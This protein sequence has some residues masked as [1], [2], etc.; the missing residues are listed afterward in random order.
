MRKLLGPS[1]VSLFF[2][3]T[4]HA[5]VLSYGAPSPAGFAGTLDAGGQVPFSGSPTFSLRVAGTTNP[6][7]G[8]LLVGGA[9]V[10]LPVLG[11]T[12]LVDP[13]TAALI[14]FPA[15]LT[16]LPIPIPPAPSIVGGTAYAQV[17]I[18]NGAFPPLGIALT[19]AVSV[20][21]LP[22]PTPT[23]AYFGLQDFSFGAN[24]P[25]QM[26]I[27]DLTTVPPSFR[28]TGNLGFSG[29]IASNFSPKVAVPEQAGFAYALGSQSVNQ[30]VRVLDVASDPA[31]IVTYASLGDIPV[32]LPI[33][34][35]VGQRECETTPDNSLLFVTSGNSSATVL[36]E[37]FD[38][39]SLPGS[40]PTAP[41][42]TIS[43]ATAGS[44]PV[45]LDVSPDGTMLAVLAGVDGNPPVRIYSINPAAPAP[46]SLA[47]SL[48]L[49][50]FTG[51]ADPHD[52]HFAPDGSLLFVSGGN[53]TFA[54]VDLTGPAPLTLINGGAWPTPATSGDHGSAV[55]V[56]G[57]ALVGVLGDGMTSGGPQYYV[58]DLNTTSASFGTLLASFTTNAVGGNI[59]NH[60][61]HARGSIVV[62]IDG[63]GAT[64]DCEWID[65]VDLNQPDPV[66]GFVSWRVKA[67]TFTNL[68]PTGLSSIPR[69]FDIR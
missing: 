67:P 57:G 62:A 48:T 34:D 27:L 69:D 55:A 6:I 36:L 30:F 15:P 60:R 13:T 44:G 63:G 52:V 43:Y 56:M 31:G 35:W 20:E 28:A 2:A 58:I 5:Q 39:S 37:A 66:M 24:A 17:A 47:A 1:L 23:R 38:L 51:S 46:L 65:V 45:N 50:G 4:A 19:N 33:F 21:I 59:S 25:G 7:G 9:P 64:A 61:V 16:T 32:G 12:V 68:A 42:Q 49:T 22:D 3:A 41:V 8:L 10:S 26:A 29:N 40:L 14:P 54:V 11:L 18:A 53:G